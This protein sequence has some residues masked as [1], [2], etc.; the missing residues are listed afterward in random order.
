MS[1]NSLLLSQATVVQE[2]TTNIR[3]DYRFLSQVGNGAFAD[4][5]LAEHRVTKQKRC[6]KAILRS[7]DTHYSD[8]LEEVKLLK[9]MDH[10]HIVKI[11][12]YYT[13]KNH[14][15]IVS[16]FLEGGEL[17]SKV[18]KMNHHEESNIARIM[19][20]ILSAVAYIHNHNIIH[21]DL[22]PENVVF[23]NNEPNSNIKIIDFGTCIKITENQKL[24]EKLGTCYYVAPEVLLRHY[25]RKCDIWSCGVILYVLLCGYPPFN[26]KRD[27]EIFD[28]ILKGT[29]SFPIEEWDNISSHAKDLITQMF[30]FDQRKRPEATDLLT[31][32]WFQKCR[33]QEIHG[34]LDSKILTNLQ[35]FHS[36]SVFK[37]AIILFLTGFIDLKSE[38]DQLLAIFKELDTDHDGQLTRAE[39]IEAYKRVD[40][41]DDPETIVTNI[42]NNLDFN[43]TEAIDFTEFL[44]ANVDY[45][46]KLRFEHLKQIFK[47][48]DKN[49]DGYL[50]L[51]EMAEF[52]AGGSPDQQEI[53]EQIMKEVDKNRDGVISF[54]EFETAIQRLL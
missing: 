38:K 23:E 21:R 20:Q 49:A 54:A 8:I 53:G 37:N 34:L 2:H 50:S 42:L 27:S 16:E 3:D 26:G 45:R 7:P 43:K 33:K 46:Q 4:V 36:N 9:E 28:K 35:S 32:P 14:I 44:V 40:D 39:L 25:D 31:H 13:T 15:Y 41:I 12:E 10:P 24:R 5:Y 29:F 22:K 47:V 48:I 1:Q 11:Y 19:E 18:A 17:F 52:F 51:N 6:I 30:T